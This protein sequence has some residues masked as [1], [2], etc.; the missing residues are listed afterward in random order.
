VGGLSLSSGGKSR[1]GSDPSTNELTG[2]W[3]KGDRKR[4]CESANGLSHVSEARLCKGS[5]EG[6]KRGVAEGEKARR[7]LC[8][9]VD[10]RALM[11]G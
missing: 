8:D 11:A 5:G 4:V 7:T 1:T 6:K 3:D 2:R 9:N 10:G